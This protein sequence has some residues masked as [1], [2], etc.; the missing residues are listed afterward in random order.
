MSTGY[1]FKYYILVN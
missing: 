1:M